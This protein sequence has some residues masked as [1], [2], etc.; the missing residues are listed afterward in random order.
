MLELRMKTERHASKYVNKYFRDHIHFDSNQKNECG[1]FKN[2]KSG[3]LLT[4]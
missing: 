4:C 2:G 1:I 3:R